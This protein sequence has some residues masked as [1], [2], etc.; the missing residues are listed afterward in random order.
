MVE[1]GILYVRFKLGNI[2]DEHCKSFLASEFVEG[3]IDVLLRWT[4][5]LVTE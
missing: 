3:V 5:L 1:S 4:D 2:L